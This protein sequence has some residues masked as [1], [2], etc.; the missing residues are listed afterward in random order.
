MTKDELYEKGIRLR[1]EMFGEAGAEGQVEN[2]SPLMEKLQDVVTRYCFGDIWQR[3]GLDQRT[4]SMVTLGMLV[5]LG[6]EHETK[7]HLRG[8]L[9]NG[10]TEDEIREI[11]IHSFL[12]CG[13]PAAANGLKAVEEVLAAAAGEAVTADA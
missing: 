3:D 4:R 13:I 6:R 12:Y 8:A 1:R 10:V 5:A 2:A 11:M 7:I 9:A